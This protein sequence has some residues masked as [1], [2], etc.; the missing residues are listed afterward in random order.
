MGHTNGKEKPPIDTK[1]TNGHE[2]A[3]SD[4]LLRRSVAAAGSGS[5]GVITYKDGMVK[6]RQGNDKIRNP[7]TEIRKKAEDR[8]ALS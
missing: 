3:C 8:P 5:Y 2:Y 1:D 7:R 4:E 6:K